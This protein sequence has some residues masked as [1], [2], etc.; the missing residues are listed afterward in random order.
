[1]NLRPV[2]YGYEGSTYTRMARLALELKGVDH[3]FVEVAAWD[4]TEKIP[5]H[6]GRHPFGKVP[7]F[8]HGSFEIYETAAI[9]R[10]VDE[11]FPGPPLQPVDARGR[12]RMHQII[13][14]H[15]NY[16][17]P[18]WVRIL[19]SEIHFNPLYGTPVDEALVHLIKQ[20]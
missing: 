4:G 1:M 10:Y 2:L 17:Q 15:D 6:K 12:A 20:N 16:I 5:E 3:D 14:V 9:T 19:A 18:C 8:C 7:V 11:C 13:C